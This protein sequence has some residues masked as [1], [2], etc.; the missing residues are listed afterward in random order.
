MKWNHGLGQGYKTYQNRINNVAWRTFRNVV[1][2]DDWCDR[3]GC[4]GWGEM[5]A[6][7]IKKKK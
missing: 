4:L 1:Q 2:E 5:E 3:R 7:K 6:I